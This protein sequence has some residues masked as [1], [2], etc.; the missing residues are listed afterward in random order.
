MRVKAAFGQCPKVS[1]F[2]FRNDFPYTLFHYNTITLF[3]CLSPCFPLLYLSQFISSHCQTIPLIHPHILPLLRVTK[4]H[5]HPITYQCQTFPLS[6]TKPSLPS[7]TTPYRCKGLGCF[8]LV[9]PAV[10]LDKY[11]PKYYTVILSHHHTVPLSL[12]DCYIIRLSTITCHCG[13]HF[14]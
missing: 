6:P 1:S 11:R 5:H 7:S 12:S 4:S 3:H 8:V 14:C 10:D 13:P 9:I 2:F